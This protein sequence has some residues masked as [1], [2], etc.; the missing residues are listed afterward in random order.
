V[1]SKTLA[2]VERLEHRSIVVVA[3]GGGSG[4]GSALPTSVDGTPG[5]DITATESS[6]GEFHFTELALVDVP[7]QVTFEATGSYVTPWVSLPL[8]AFPDDL[9][10]QPKIYM[11]ESVL[12]NVRMDLDAPVNYQ[13]AMN[14]YSLGREP[15]VGG[16]FGGGQF[17]KF[18]MNTGDPSA[19]P[20]AVAQSGS[21][22]YM[23][24]AWKPNYSHFAS[25]LDPAFCAAYVGPG[26]T[27]YLSLQGSGAD[28]GEDPPAAS[29][30]VLFNGTVRFKWV[31]VGILD[32]IIHPD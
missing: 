17:C 24:H 13:N 3:A 31:K 27:L 25:S 18:D 20:L 15:L 12:V 7:A 23:Q 32:N 26:L 8:Y 29:A 21:Q 19:Q 1:S 5:D 22:Y 11:L 28:T 10:G 9:S 6:V 30:P 2:V 16:G 4:S 14:G